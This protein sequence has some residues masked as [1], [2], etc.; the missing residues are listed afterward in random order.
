[1]AASILCGRLKPGVSCCFCRPRNR[2]PPGVFQN[3]LFRL[4]FTVQVGRDA[5]NDICYR[6]PYVSGR[7]ARLEG[8]DGRMFIIDLG[9]ANGTFVNGIRI[10]NR[11]VFPGDIIYINGLKILPGKGF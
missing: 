11:E 8:R 9:S 4:S 7:H 3:L 1:M 5:E 6:L 2:R 10:D